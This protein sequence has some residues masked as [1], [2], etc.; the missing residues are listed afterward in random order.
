MDND[1]ELFEEIVRLF[2]SDAP[3]QMQHILQALVQGDSAA[4]QHAAHTIK[5][6][7]GIFSAERTV[8]AAARLEQLAASGSLKPGAL[9]AAAELEGA[10]AELQ[11][12]LLLYQW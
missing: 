8:Q 3:V 5:G 7:V 9:E 4:V 10:M 1:R 6:M 12:A 11:A 2:Q